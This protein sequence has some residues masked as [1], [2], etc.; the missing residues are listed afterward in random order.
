[1]NAK[2]KKEVIERHKK[3][4]IIT[5]TLTCETGEECIIRHPAIKTT[6]KVLN[7]LFGEN[8]DMLKAGKIILDDCW[9]AGDDVIRTDEELNGEVAFAA[10]TTVEF[11]I[12]EVKKN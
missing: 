8:R 11:K 5:Y 9:I 6:N 3:S 12:A 2:Q 7:Y 4:G 1:M 10:S